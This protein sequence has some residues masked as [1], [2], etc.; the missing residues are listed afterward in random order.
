MGVKMARE[1]IKKVSRQVFRKVSKFNLSQFGCVSEPPNKPDQTK[2][3]RRSLFPC[4][5]GHAA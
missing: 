5:K 4:L 3:K 1:I 2:R